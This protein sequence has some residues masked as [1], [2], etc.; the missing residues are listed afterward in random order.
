MQP[1]CTASPPPTRGS[2]HNPL[3]LTCSPAE[4]SAPYTNTS[5]LYYDFKDTKCM[6]DYL[7]TVELNY[8]YLTIFQITFHCQM[9]IGTTVT[10]TSNGRQTG[11]GQP[12]TSQPSGQPEEQDQAQA[13]APS[14]H[15]NGAGQPSGQGTPRVIRITHQTMEPV[16]MMQMNLDGK[17]VL[18]VFVLCLVFV[19]GWKYFILAL[20]LY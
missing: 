12:Q 11:E 1:G 18:T 16:V 17:S 9:N 7:N 4:W 19:G 2:A 3:H 10:M 13:Q 15:S 5:E 8:A 14:A 6:K 20:I